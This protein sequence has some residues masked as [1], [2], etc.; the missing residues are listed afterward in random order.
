MKLT[1]KVTTI[2]EMRTAET[3]NQTVSLELVRDAL[4][5]YPLGSNISITLGKEDSDKFDIG[6]EVTVTIE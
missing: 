6:Q 2:N 4:N 3:R 1:Y 5:T